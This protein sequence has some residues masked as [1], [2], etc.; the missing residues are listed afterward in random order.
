MTMTPQSA[1][2]RDNDWPD[3]F[4]TLPL[5]ETSISGSADSRGASAQLKTSHTVVYR[6]LGV[7]NMASGRLAAVP[8]VVAALMPDE[9]CGLERDYANGDVS[10][11]VGKILDQLRTR[12]IVFS[13]GR[14]G[15]KRYYGDATVLTSA[16][17][18]QLPT[19]GSRRQRVLQLVCEAV[20]S[21]GE[22]VRATD[23]VELAASRADARD[24]TRTFIIRDLQNLVRTGDIRVVG[25]VRGGGTDGRSLY[26]PASFD[27]GAY[28]YRPVPR[29]WLEVVDA[30]VRRCWGDELKAAEAAGRRSRPVATGAVRA[31][32]A[33]RYAPDVASADCDV[34]MPDD[35][36]LR[37]VVSANLQDP[38]K[39]VNAMQSLAG[40]GTPRI[41]RVSRSGGN[42]RGIPELH[43][44]LWAPADVPDDALDIGSAFTSDA[45]RVAEAVRRA[46]RARGVP[47]VQRRAVEEEVALDAALR[48]AGEQ[49]IARVLA[50]A[51]RGLLSDGDAA[52]APRATILI[53][54]LGHVDGEAYYTASDDDAAPKA[55]LEVLQLRADWRDGAVDERLCEVCGATIPSVALGRALLLRDE[56]RRVLAGLESVE[57]RGP[58]S[59]R[60]MAVA[61]GERLRADIMRVAEHAQDTVAE[62]L[63]LPTL[64]GADALP[65]T[66]DPTVP[67]WTA[68]E[69]LSVL[70]EVYPRAGRVE[71]PTELVPLLGRAVRRVP[72]P[73]FTWRRA[74]P[75]YL[76]DQAD[77][78]LYAA[79]QWGGSE[80]LLQAT[81]GEAELDRLRDVRFVSPGLTHPDCAVRLS[82]VACLA[83]LWSDE[84]CAAMRQAALTDPEPGVRRAALWGYGFAGGSSPETLAMEVCETDHSPFVRGL[85]E[86]VAMGGWGWWAT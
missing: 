50:D 59:R 62:A 27:P 65:D 13:P 48:P 85:A 86:R 14:V 11:I 10:V 45:E 39:L 8:D 9:R 7:A 33:V 16:D 71:D 29:S 31:F 78:L 26:L 74:G 30:A 32:L 75:E 52:R 41:R 76:F 28:P 58:A 82:T 46:C 68:E 72:S 57:S 54:G 4:L 61:A 20:R 44:N 43:A 63:R 3:D 2:P 38:I 51:S 42:T 24:L 77:A 34:D 5:P 80:C 60:G 36:H 21:T 64:A 12:H 84:S 53:R 35:L 25:E 18:R 56:A 83:F 37:S 67:G 17:S 40:S 73:G 49:S 66:P 19:N 69:L 79:K 6:A 70:R 81:L 55:Y 47:A 22:P 15:Q 23:I 1:S